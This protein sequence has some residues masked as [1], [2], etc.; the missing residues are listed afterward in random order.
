MT[1]R[2]HRNR[3]GRPAWA[4]L[5]ASCGLLSP[6]AAHAQVQP[7]AA[8]PQSDA[9]QAK[10][11][12]EEIIVTAQ[13]R[14]EKLSDVPLSITAATGDQLANRGITDTSQLSKI[15]PGFTFQQSSYGTPVF[16]I[17]GIGFF[18]N[19]ILA[20][21]TVTTYIDQ[22]PQPLSVMTRGSTLDLERVEVLKGP[23]GTL[24]GQ[25]STGGAINYIAAKPTDALKAGV[26]LG[27]GRFNEVIAGGFVSGPLSETV[28]ARLAVRQE[29][30]AG[31]QQSQTRPG[32]TL[33]RKRF[34]NG[35]L[36]LDWEPSDKVKFEFSASGWIDRS[37]GLAPQL[38]AFAA[39]NPVTPLTQYVADAMNA[40]P[41]N[42][43]SARAADWT[44]GFDYARND[45]YYLLSLRADWEISDVISLTSITAYSHLTT[46]R[47][48]DTDGSAFDDFRFDIQNGRAKM[49][50][51]E[52]RLNGELG[53]LRWMIGGNYQNLTGSEYQIIDHFS[54]TDVVDL[55]PFGLPVYI[56]HSNSNYQKQRP[57]TKSVFASLDFAVTEQLRAY[58]S[59]RYSDER[60]RFEGC[61]GDSGRSPTATSVPI[62]TAFG[63]LSSVL[64]GSPTVV[65]PFGCLTFNDLTAK[66]GL[67]RRNLNEDN[68]SWRVGL[69]WKPSEEMLLYVNATKG[70]KSGSF[71][72]VPAI[73]ESQFQPV[74]Q[75]AVLAYDAGVK[76]SLADRRVQLTGAVFYYD[77]KNKQLLGFY[78]SGP[79]GQLPKLIN[80]PKS[81]VYGA[82]IEGTIR[83]V[84]GLVLSGGVTYVNSRVRSDPRAPDVPLDPFAQPTSYIGEA[85]PNTPKWQAVLDAEY[86]F[87]LNRSLN[88]VVGG[89]AT[90]LS[91]SYAA[92]GESP[93]F[94]MPSYTVFD[95]RAGVESA[96]ERWR[97][98]LWG[99]NIGNKLY[100]TNVQH[101]IDSVARTVG[102]PATYG[103]SLAYR[104]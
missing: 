16:A 11:T 9:L 30:M 94:L 67:V 23:Q 84:D 44:P 24:F 81:R 83:P 57:I 55:S 77:Y 82:E 61:L 95:V 101:L 88:A 13:K 15:V 27:Y 93:I 47:P 66:P 12:V 99:R 25:N 10:G 63:A 97:L 33:G 26:D 103:V 50:S 65:A 1:K 59:A 68:V 86:S 37:D 35:R 19:S 5:I 29:Y 36:L 40:S 69:D 41:K 42:P 91:S 31:W 39:A 102:M 14:E 58:A 92:F 43:G 17:R 64:S 98:Q 34:S 49:F 4:A 28:R 51:Q 100:L 2:M 79:F 20:G 7:G 87:A 78:D 72:I 80:I 74:T 32:D 22:V 89:S 62:R 8:A 70:Y 96:D 71:S 104:Y 38:L 60:R 56:Q 3:V 6:A 53:A 52:L 90:H 85:F 73:F 75:E 46:D 45:K 54:T 76:L 18:D 21:P 48:V